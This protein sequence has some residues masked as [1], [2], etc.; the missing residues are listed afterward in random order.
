MAELPMTGLGRIAGQ[1]QRMSGAMAARMLVAAMALTLAGPLMAQTKAPKVDP[2]KGQQIASQVCVACHMADGN[3]ATPAN[4]KL[5]GQH[6]D[7]LYKQLAN[8][9]AKPGAKQAERVNPIMAGFAGK[10]SDED[11]RN[12][13]AHFSSQ[14]QKPSAAR[15]KETVEQGQAIYRGGIAA[16]NVPACA[17]CHSPN[18]AGIPAQYPRLAGQF[19][20]YTESQLVAFRQGVRKNGEQMTA[21]AARLSDDEIKAVSDYI[22]GLR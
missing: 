22:A 15:N 1:V 4:P 2:A 17:G 6:A 19:A 13:A 14:T 5:A 12:L 11:M 8:F 20:E 21:I 3:S 16:K 7:Y 10:L 18:G 9:K